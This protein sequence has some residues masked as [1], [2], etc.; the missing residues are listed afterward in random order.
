MKKQ[1]QKAKKIIEIHDWWNYG[2]NLITGYRVPPKLLS[3]TPV[4]NS[5]PF[6]KDLK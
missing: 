6:P 2:I 3:K 1:L 4:S 5:L